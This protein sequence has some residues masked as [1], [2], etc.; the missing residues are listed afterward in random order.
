MSRP[1]VVLDACA[2]IPIR[3][4]TTLLGLAEADLFTPL[5]S[6]EILDEIERNLPAVGGISADSA[7]KRISAMREGFGPESMVSGY[8]H[9]VES[10]RCDPKD[11]HVL[12]TAVAADADTLVTFNLRDFLPQARDEHGVNVVHPDQFLQ[13]LLNAHPDDVIDA[14][15]RVVGA[16]RRPPESLNDFLGHLTRVVPSFANLAAFSATIDEE[17]SPVP[18]VVQA[19]IDQA[20]AQFGHPG[21]ATQPGVVLYAWWNGLMRGDLDLTRALTAD[22]AAFGDFRWVRERLAGL[23]LASR[24]LRAVD[25]PDDLAFMRFVPESPTTVQVFAPVLVPSVVATLVRIEDGS[26]RVWGLGNAMVSAA[27]V[28]TSR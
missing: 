18:A 13:Q 10:M 3:L 4:A 2:L 24:V 19:D 25:A 6:E 26:W 21:D 27:E 1:A 23:G 7:Q 28:F 5:W 12:A 9:L 16:R 15:T 17:L 11:Q 14:L 8:G 20:V 22:P